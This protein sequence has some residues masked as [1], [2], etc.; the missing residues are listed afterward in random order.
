MLTNLCGAIPST[1][2]NVVDGCLNLAEVQRIYLQR[3]YSSGVTLNT[4]V[5]SSANPNL[6]ASWTAKLTATDGT[7]ILA[8]SSDGAL[9]T[10]TIHAPTFAVGNEITYGGNGETAG[11][12][13][14]FLG[15]EPGAFEAKLIARS[16]L[17]IQGWKLKQGESLSVF[18]ETED[19]R[20]VGATDNNTSPTIFKG[21][22]I[23]Q[24]RV[25]DRSGDK[26]TEPGFNMLKFVLPEGWSDY[27]YAVTPSNF[28]ARTQ[29]VN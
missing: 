16:A 15:F 12:I 11:G 13:P 28:V 17:A 21:I 2:G 25:S 5:I 6:L 9:G 22:R 1:L 3:T 29:I 19:G 26:R 23:E 8:P 4:F 18:F 27:L 10:A 20:I 24:F 7:K 14:I